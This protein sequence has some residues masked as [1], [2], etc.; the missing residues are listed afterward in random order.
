MSHRRLRVLLF[1]EAVTLAH[2]ARPIALARALDPARYEVMLACDPRYAAFAS[3]GNWQRADLRSIS[4]AQFNQALA[5]GAPVYDLATLK[6]YVEQDRLLIEAFKPDLIV[7]DFRL[8]LS[9]SA[10]LARVP[11]LAI[12]NAY[13]CPHYQGGF[14]LPVLPMTRF[15]PLPLASALFATFRPIAFAMHCQPMNQLRRRH[16]LPL[17]GH[18]LRR[19]YSDADH[20]LLPDVPSLYPVDSGAAPHSFIGPLMWSPSV[21]LPGW[22]HEPVPEGH[23]TVYVTL[24][25]SGPSALLAMVLAALDGL[26][27]RVLAS[28]AGAAAPSWV[29]ANARVAAY[30]PGDAAATRSQLVVCNGGSLTAQQA[31]AAGVP[32]LGLCS[33]MDQFL[34]MAPIEAAGAGLTLRADRLSAASIRM[35]CQRLLSSSAAAQAAKRLQP[36]LHPQTP[37]AEAFD[38]AV[39]Q[40]M[41][42]QPG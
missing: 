5:R 9:V 38:K 26:P 13:W 17:L 32:L 35:A 30:L 19:V 27:V 15:L 14:L 25:S 4:A 33:N 39:A 3:G 20:Q 21:A 41:P 8:S 18:D 1:A 37:I 12:T 28:A 2:V 16:G 24:G 11:Y 6:S 31:L 42:G 7:G 23:A 36:L 10:R 34:N 22:W 29:P 40:V